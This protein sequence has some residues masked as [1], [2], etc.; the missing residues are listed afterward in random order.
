MLDDSTPDLPRASQP[1][2]FPMWQDWFQSLYYSPWTSSSPASTF[3]TA[4]SSVPDSLGLQMFL[5][6]RF[7]VD[8]S[9][10]PTISHINKE[11][12]ALEVFQV[13]HP[14]RQPDTPAEL[15]T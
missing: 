8:L 10:Y 14:R 13:S 15:R 7:K 1:M 11:L 4:H 5:C 12:L 2:R 9:P 3:H 6:H